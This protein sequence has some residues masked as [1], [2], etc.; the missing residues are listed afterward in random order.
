MDSMK[1]LLT[2]RDMGSMVTLWRESQLLSCTDV[3]YLQRIHAT[4][5]GKRKPA[6][7]PYCVTEVTRRDMAKSAENSDEGVLA[8]RSL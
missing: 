5:K 6:T 3:F 1:C 2:T 4:E 8:V 7:K